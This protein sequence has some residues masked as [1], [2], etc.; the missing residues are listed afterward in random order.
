[1]KKEQS[2]KGDAV[3]A[4]RQTQSAKRLFMEQGGLQRLF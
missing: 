1:M 2:V 3:K 4:K